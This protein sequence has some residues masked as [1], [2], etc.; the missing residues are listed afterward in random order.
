MTD[1][2]KHLLA[3][4]YNDAANQDALMSL[5]RVWQNYNG[6]EATVAD[7]ADLSKLICRYQDQFPAKSAVEVLRQIGE[8]NLG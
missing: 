1:G 4:A 2:A 3:M 8:G 7:V 5:L 6:L